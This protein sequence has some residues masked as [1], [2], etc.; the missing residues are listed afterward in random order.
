MAL[1]KR[2][3]ALEGSA[4][5]MLPGARRIGPADTNERLSVTIHLHRGSEAKEFH[6]LLQRAAAHP[7]RREK[8]L[9]RQEFARMHAAH[10]TALV[11]V[12]EF[13][14]EHDLTIESEHPAERRVVLSSTVAA[15]SAA[16]GNVKLDRYDS[17][18]GIYRG[19]TGEITL[20]DDLAPYV[21]AVTGLDN[22]PVAR[23]HFRRSRTS[24]S[25]IRPHAEGGSSFTATQVSQLYDFPDT[26]DGSGQCIGIIEL[27]GGYN[28]TDLQ[29]YFQNLNLPMPNVQSV[30]VNGATNQPA[31][32]PDSPDGE[33][34]L[35]IE[36]AG[37]VAPGANI[38]VY[39]APGSSDDDFLNAVKT[40]VH[41][42][43][44]SPSVISISWGGAESLNTSQFMQA[45]DQAFQDA[46]SMGVT[47]CCAAGD[48]GSSDLRLPNE[49]D[50]GLLHVDFP[51]SSPFALACGGTLLKGSGNVINSE[52]VWNEGRQEGATG[53]GVSEV[54][55][56]PTWQSN[57]GVPVSANPSQF[58]GRGV[59]DVAGNADPESG[60]QIIVD[61]QSG[62]IGGTSAV[63]PLWAGLIALFNQRLG[64]H[65]GYLNPTLYGIA[66]GSGSFHDI[67]SGNNDISGNNGPY[68][69]GPG[70]D[71][72]TGLGSPDGAKL[73]AT[74]IGQ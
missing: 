3:V 56:L 73:L 34:D 39:F 21:E 8:H 6:S 60:Y 41:D 43:T 50:D 14:R 12:R 15:M 64:H 66:T 65:V 57:T 29:N 62:V 20:P 25:G 48:D 70:W 16:F 63:A 72:T 68:A 18:R 9:S 4:R 69:A 37:A 2:R 55:P 61:G 59:P 46:A 11:K 58:E 51:A 7:M 27:G 30:S 24:R 31:P 33:V 23:P 67:Q 36:V 26:L 45:M 28:P 42:S 54:F 10:P 74:L 53:G 17:S 13:A 52:A 71:P 44:N 35:D 49:P 1:S 47:I 19:R 38:V 5:E 40:A 32:G 22:R